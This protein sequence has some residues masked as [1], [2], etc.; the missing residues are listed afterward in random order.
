MS[1]KFDKNKLYYN[2]KEIYEAP[3]DI[4]SIFN[5]NAHDRVFIIY[6]GRNLLPDDY[7]DITNP[8][9]KDPELQKTIN[10]NVLCID[11]EG[12]TLWQID[13]TDDRPIDFTHLFEEDGNL[14]AYRRDAE[15][16]RIDPSNG[17]I[18]EFR[19]GI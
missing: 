16:Y 18:L 8:R 5:D 17:K 11:S 9:L 15:E 12:N 19:M 10:Q 3:T 6:R 2:D 1:Y 4:T 13:S 14:W 7:H